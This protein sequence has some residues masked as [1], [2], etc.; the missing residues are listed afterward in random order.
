MDKNIAVIGCGYWGKN[1]V[2]NFAELGALHTICDSSPDVLNQL[3]AI[4][5]HAQRETSYEIVL[6]NSEIKGVVIA[7][8]AAVHYSMA[9]Q[10]LL[11]GKDVFVEKPFTTKSEDADELV[12]LSV[13]QQRI[14]MVGHLLLYHPAVQM[15]K[16]YIQSGKLGEIYY[17]YSTR[18]NLGQIR[19]DENAL[20]RLVPHD[21]AMFIY[22]LEE[23]PMAVSAQGSSYLQPDFVDVVFATLKFKTA[24]AHVHASWLDPHKMRQL[25]IVGSKKMVVFN[26]MEPEYILQIYDKGVVTNTLLTRSGEV[27]YPQVELTEPLLLECQEFIECMAEQKQPLSDAKQGLEVVKTLEAAHKSMREGGRQISISEG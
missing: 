26:D 19:Q 2:R 14:L 15:L 27:I 6:A 4:Y 1:L 13:N 22:L 7:S 18:V 9:R 3:G 24:L 17:L 25:T 5:P 12:E 23:T 8:P 21:I 20:W 11:A 10:A 16:R